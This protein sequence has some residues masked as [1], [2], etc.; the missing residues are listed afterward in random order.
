MF[1]YTFEQ[2]RQFCVTDQNN[3]SRTVNEVNSEIKN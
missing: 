2:I 3:R 1:P